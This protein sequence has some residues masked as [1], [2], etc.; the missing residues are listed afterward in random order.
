MM[1]INVNA[2]KIHTNKT[3]L[4]LDKT[5]RL[6]SKCSKKGSAAKFVFDKLKAL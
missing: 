3:F 6:D 1:D 5:L 4:F 2:E